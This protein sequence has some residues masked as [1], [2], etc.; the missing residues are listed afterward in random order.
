MIYCNLE[1]PILYTHKHNTHWD[2]HK[3]NDQRWGNGKCFMNICWMFSLSPISSLSSQRAHP[4]T[5]LQIS[6]STWFSPPLPH[7]WCHCLPAAQTRNL[8]SSL[9]EVCIK[10][11][12]VS[13][14]GVQWIIRQAQP[15]WHLLSQAT[16]TRKSVHLS[17]NANQPDKQDE[18]IQLECSHLPLLLIPESNLPRE[19]ASMMVGMVVIHGH[20]VAKT[21]TQL[22]Y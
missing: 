20:G 19:W 10:L 16:S 18:L 11:L 22:S 14:L 3:N 9:K 13:L 6:T 1:L 21:W 5:I 12:S 17:R 2:L 15:L 7:R 8:I 4:P